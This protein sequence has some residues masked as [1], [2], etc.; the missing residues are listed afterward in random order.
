[1]P[2]YYLTTLLSYSPLSSMAFSVQWWS[3]TVLASVGPTYGGDGRAP[4]H[5][6]L[7]I[8]TLVVRGLGLLEDKVVQI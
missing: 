7:V 5:N 6:Q 3:L 4:G 2:S 1:M 8:V